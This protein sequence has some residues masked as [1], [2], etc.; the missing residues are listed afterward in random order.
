MVSHSI[1]DPHGN[2]ALVLIMLTSSIDQGDTKQNQTYTLL[3]VDIPHEDT[4]AGPP[5]TPL[6]ADDNLTSEA[7]PRSP[8][9]PQID[10]D[11]QAK[12]LECLEE[13]E[14]LRVKLR[15]MGTLPRVRTSIAR[16]NET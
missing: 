13:L 10:G 11:R 1:S 4:E 16:V 8:T 5:T 7:T 15:K 9:T 14:R 3:L 6:E 2:M 12:L